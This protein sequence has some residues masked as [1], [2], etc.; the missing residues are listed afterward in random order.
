VFRPLGEAEVARIASLL[1]AESSQR[2]ASEKGIA[3]V[4]GQD[5]VAVLL[6]SGGFDRSLGARP[7][8]QVVQRLVEAP[9]AEGIL[10]GEF[11]SGDRIRVF[12][13]GNGLA[14][15]REARI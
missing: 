10:K 4:C 3:Y 8:R 9:I 14:F 12:A 13:Q 11:V 7:M 15:R 1:L 6:G 5:V 2:L